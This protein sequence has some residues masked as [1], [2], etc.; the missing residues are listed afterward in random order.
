M[1]RSSKASQYVQRTP[2]LL[3]V[4]ANGGNSRG[5]PNLYCYLISDLLHG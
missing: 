4:A 2:Q 3:S 5:L 1:V